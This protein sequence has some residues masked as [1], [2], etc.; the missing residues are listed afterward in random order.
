VISTPTSDTSYTPLVNLDSNTLYFWRVSS[1]RNNA[2]YSPLD[3]L[4]VVKAP[5]VVAAKQPGIKPLV[6]QVS[7]NPFSG[8]I[9]VTLNTAASAGTVSLQIFD[10]SGRLVASLVPTGGNATVS[11]RWDGRDAGGVKARAGIYFLR[12]KVGS[13][14]LNER[15]HLLR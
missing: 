2:A 13:K 9:K 7:P 1:S 14:I 15:I 11:A 4:F 3:S 5:S 12:A 10:V 8:A 6:L